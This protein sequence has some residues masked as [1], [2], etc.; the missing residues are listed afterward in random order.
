MNKIKRS[1]F[2]KLTGKLVRKLWCYYVI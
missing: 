1:N 2:L